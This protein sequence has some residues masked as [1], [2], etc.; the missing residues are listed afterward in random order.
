MSILTF[1]LTQAYFNLE[2]Q[3]FAAH[4]RDLDA[5]ILITGYLCI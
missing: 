3:D 4:L 2:R 5:I 1:V